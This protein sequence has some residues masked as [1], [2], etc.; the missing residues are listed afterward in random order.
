[1]PADAIPSFR[2]DDPTVSIPVQFLGKHACGGDVLF[3]GVSRKA[4]C[5]QCGEEGAHV[6]KDDPM[7]FEI[8]EVIDGVR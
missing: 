1:M 8:T 6:A 4:V 7:N 3:E 2:E 5:A